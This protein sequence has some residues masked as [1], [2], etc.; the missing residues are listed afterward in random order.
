MITENLISINLLVEN[1]DFC[2]VR[3][4]VIRL[5]GLDLACLLFLY[6]L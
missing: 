2:K 1:N 6:N 5:W 4:V 3:D